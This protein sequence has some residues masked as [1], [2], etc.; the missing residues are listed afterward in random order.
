MSKNRNRNLFGRARGLVHGFFVNAFLPDY[1]NKTKNLHLWGKD[2]LLPQKLI[3]YVADSGVATRAYKKVSEYIASDG[4]ANKEVSKIM[5]NATQTADK[6][7]QVQA[8]YMGLLNAAAFHITRK[9]GL[10]NSIEVKAIPVQCVRKQIEGGGYI[11]NETLGQPEYKKE[12]DTFYMPFVSR[13]LTKD[14]YTS[15]QYKSGEILFVHL[16]T[17][18][19]QYYP[20]P[21]YYAQIEDVRTSSEISKMDL[22]LSIN[23]F[24]PS[25]ILT[26]VGDIDNVTKGQDGLTDLE[27]TQKDFRQFTGQMKDD[28]GGSG[29]F[30][31]MLLFAPTKD[32]IPNLQ[33][34]D[35]KS[36]LEGTNS[37]RDIVSRAVAR[38]FGV[39]PVLLGFEDANVL[40]NQQAMANAAAELNKVVN[41]LQRILTEAFLLLY[42]GLDWTISEYKTINHIPDAVLAVLTPDEKRALAGYPALTNPTTVINA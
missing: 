21:D 8:A 33:Q 37:K 16:E 40:G 6:L 32:E 20:V 23:G 10:L 15:K 27:A 39:H 41:P 13:D 12:K 9:G 36:T 24:M 18:Y 2:N 29:R 1:Q 26:I 35:L 19:N 25:S 42:P 14:E 17:P 28:N 22:E 3:S 38:L 31:G 7:L 5:V 4:F 34:L 30:K 11:Y